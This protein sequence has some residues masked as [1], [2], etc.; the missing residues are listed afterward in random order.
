M[1]ATEGVSEAASV[2]VSVSFR[3]EVLPAQHP[4]HGTPDPMV[5]RGV[6]VEVNGRR[7]ALEQ[8]DYGHPGRFNPP[9]LRRVS[10][11]LAGR[12]AQLKALVPVLAALASE[13]P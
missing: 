9:Q 11:A 5:R 4:S 2:R 7:A 12:E 13:P 1:P 10:A 3:Q 8:T 6:E